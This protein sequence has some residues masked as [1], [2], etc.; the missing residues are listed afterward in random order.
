M[1]GLAQQT[2]VEAVDGP[3]MIRDLVGKGMPV[4]TRLP[5]GARGFRILS[6]ITPSPEPVPIQ[7]LTLDNG[8]AA[9]VAMDQI[10][11][12]AGGVPVAARDVRP[13]DVLE[14]SFHYPPG[15]RLRDAPPG[16]PAA[17][18]DRPGLVVAAAEAAGTDIVYSGRV[19]ETGCLF[20]TCGILCRMRHLTPPGDPA[21]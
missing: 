19:N 9:A 1:P 3:A 13:G 11:Y 15:Y 6:K 12:R 21:T 10:V 8:R 17:A 5:S 2:L 18:S 20:L 14:A 16:S 4:L 7:R